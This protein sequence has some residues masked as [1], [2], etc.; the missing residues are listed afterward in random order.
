MGIYEWHRIFSKEQIKKRINDSYE[1][2][3]RVVDLIPEPLVSVITS[4]YQHAPYI[5]DC[6]EGVLMQK[7][8]FPIE[9]IIGEDFSTDGTREI[10]FEYAKKYP[11]IIRVITADYNVGGKSNSRRCHGACRGK[12]IALCEGD[13][14]WI[15]PHK[16]QKQVDS[17]E[18]HSDCMLCFHGARI[19]KEGGSGSPS[20]YLTHKPKEFVSMEEILNNNFIANA[21]VVYR[22][23]ILE[24]LPDWMERFIFADWMRNLVCAQYGKIIYID[25][26]MSIYRVHPGGVW[27]SQHNSIK[28]KVNIYTE[29]LEFYEA[30]AN[31]LDKKYLCIIDKKRVNLYLAIA[32]NYYKL[33]QKQKAL[34]CLKQAMKVTF[35]S[36][37]LTG[38]QKTR[39][40]IKTLKYVL[41]AIFKI[42]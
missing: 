37:G 13:D 39:F 32:S 14:Y 22:R 2:P 18:R 29:N 19:S 28:G 10:V 7:T 1:L 3:N 16:L 24:K 21:S 6:I 35:K 5:K 31:Y 30:A 42:S 20:F 27:S 15:D 12:Y 40:I 33:D 11:N 34:E 25:E 9:Y 17:L 41:V 26:V 4:T 8:T 38:S 23:E 36:T